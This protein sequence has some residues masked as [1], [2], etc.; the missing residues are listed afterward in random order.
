MGR[1]NNIAAMAAAGGFPGQGFLGRFDIRIYAQGSQS[2]GH[3]YVILG[4]PGNP[5]GANLSCHSP[6]KL[7]ETLMLIGARPL[8]GPESFG[9]EDRVALLNEL[10]FGHLVLVEEGEGRLGDLQPGDLALHRDGKVRVAVVRLQA[11]WRMMELHTGKELSG[12]AYSTSVTCVRIVG[13]RPNVIRPD[14]AA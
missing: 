13:V 12:W 9:E 4:L 6:E 3:P 5:P 7:W 14:L 11:G 2:H 8:S 10:S 1:F